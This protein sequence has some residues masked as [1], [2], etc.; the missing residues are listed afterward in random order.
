VLGQRPRRVVLRHH[1]GRAHR[2]AALAYPSSSKPGD[3]RVHRLVQRHSPAQHPGLSQPCRVRE[4]S[5]KRDHR[6][7]SL[8]KPS[9]LSVK[10]GQPQTRRG[11]TRYLWRFD[12]KVHSTPSFEDPEEAHVEA[13]RQIDEQIKGTWRDPRGGRIL[14]ADWINQYWWPAQDLEPTTEGN[15]AY[16]I[17]F[18]ILPA[19][20]QR[21][22]STLTYEEITT[23]ERRIRETPGRRGKPLSASTASAARSRLIT[24]LQDAADADRIP[25]NPAKRRPKRGK[26]SAASSRAATA[27]R[28]TAPPDPVTV[29]RIAERA[30]LLTSRDIDFLQVV[31]L[32]WTGMRFGETLAVE[33]QF[34]D[35]PD[36]GIP[37]YHLDW[38]LR[39]IGGKVTKAPPKDNSNRTIDLPPFLTALAK[40]LC[41]QARPCCCPEQDGQPACKG[42]DHT[43]G[44]YVFLGPGNGHPRRSNWADRVLTPAA[45]GVYPG[46]KGQRRPV[47]VS[48]QN[49]TGTPIRSTRGKRAIDFADGTWEPLHSHVWPHLFRHAHDTWLD[50]AGVR[51]LMRKDRI[52]HA[53][54]GMDSTYLHITPDARRHCC[55]ALE[56]LFWSAIGEI[57]HESAVAI[58]SSL[59]E[60]VKSRA[61]CANDGEG[62]ERR[63]V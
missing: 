15:Y 2:P 28:R 49:P 12:G 20:G 22:I 11:L 42:A 25:V 58:L 34:F 57:G 32:A 3:R 21:E 14:L 33:K 46:Q 61:T 52:G 63:S 30:A 51:E 5:Q 53:M 41:R 9:T 60:Q 44:G 17:E 23:W 55:E 27:A 56:T 35:F 43:A 24:I 54:T 13:I 59:Q 39:E 26:K 7:G 37:C 18:H 36:I 62:T 29:I 31:W 6:K 4:I 48:N 38:Q 50:D 8:T 10:A 45:T 19:F 1:Q 40:T 16:L 47:Y